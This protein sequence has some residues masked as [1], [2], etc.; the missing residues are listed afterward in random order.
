MNEESYYSLIYSAMDLGD[1]LFELWLT[2]TF[3]VILAIYFSRDQISRLMRSLL[4]ALYAG[5]A[6]LLAGRWCVAMIHIGHYM[7]ELSAAGLAPFPTPMPFGY[8]MLIL[9]FSM[10]VGGSI[11]TIYF[12]YS[13]RSSKE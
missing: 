9:H 13:Y 10:F 8:V 6:V 12:M 7:D 5:T 11:G 4:V 1:G 3:A 2:V